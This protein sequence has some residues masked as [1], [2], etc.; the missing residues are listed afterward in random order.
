MA[1][2][3]QKITFDPGCRAA[4]RLGGLAITSGGHGDGMPDDDL[5]IAN[6]DFFDEKPQDTL[7]LQC[8]DGLRRRPQSH[9]ECGQRFCEAQA[10]CTV[11]RLIDGRLQFS[12]CRLFAPSQAWHAFTQ[13]VQ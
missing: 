13:F 8:V 2:R 4:R 11:N 10:D 5:V 9:K 1:P 7:A 6:E 12:I 3:T